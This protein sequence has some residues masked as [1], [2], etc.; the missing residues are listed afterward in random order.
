MATR[1]NSLWT[2]PVAIFS[3]LFPSCSTFEPTFTTSGPENSEHVILLHGLA[4]SEKSMTKLGETLASQGFG[5]CNVGYPSTTRTIPELSESVIE[6][7]IR[8]CNLRGAT[9][10][11]FTGHS[12]GAILARYR[13][14]KSPPANAGK[15]VQLAP[16]N[17]GSEIVD[18]L[19][20]WPLFFRINGPGGLTLGTGKS[21]I[22]RQLGPVSHPT[23]VLAGNRSIN[24]ILSLLIPGQDDGKVAIER[25]KVAGTSTHEVVNASHPFIMK[26]HDVIQKVCTF[27]LQD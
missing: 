15:L 12:M 6:E 10:I 4:R 25:T 8:Q 20:D 7:A 9:K 13:L 11:H 24:P 5:V 14:E 18:K 22:I 19:G 1:S 27:L 26:K 23:L 16:P 3:V 2:L 21:S 17:Q